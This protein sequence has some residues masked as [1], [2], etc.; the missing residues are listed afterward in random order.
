[1]TDGSGALIIPVLKY[2]FSF[3]WETVAAMSPVPGT[4]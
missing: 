4:F 1:M 3:Y 2:I